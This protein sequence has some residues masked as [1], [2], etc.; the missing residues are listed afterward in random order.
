MTSTIER[1][2]VQMVFEADRFRRGIK[3]SIDDLSA[4]KKSFDFKQAQDSFSELEKASQVDFNPMAKSLEQINGKLSILGVVAAEVIQRITGAIIDNGKRMVDALVLDPILTG[5]SEYETQLNAIQTILANTRKEGVTLEDV[6]DA[7]DELNLYADLTIYNF[8]QMTD[9]IGKFTAAGVPLQD[10]VLAI[11]GIAN[12]AAVSGS[13]SQQA[14]V[15]MYQL[16][17]AISTGSLKLQDWNSVVNAGMGGQ[18]FQDALIQTARTYGVAV[19]DMIADAGSFRASLQEGWITSEILLQTLAQFTGDLSD[20]ELEALGYT[21]DEIAAIQE[22][23]ETAVDAATKIKTL[24]QLGD[25][26]KEALQSGWSES[27]R[28]IF[29][30]FEEAKELWGQ[31]AEFFGKFIDASADARNELLQTWKNAGGRTKL[32]AGFLNVMQALANIL[33]AVKAGFEAIFKPLDAA[34]L[35]RITDAFYQFSKRLLSASEN[36]GPLRIIVM[37][38]AAA[39]DVVFIFIK[40]L[41]APL[42][43]LAPALRLGAGSFADLLVG[44][45]QAI[46]KFRDFAK[47]TGFFTTLVAS[48]IAGVKALVERIKELVQGFIELEVVQTVIQWFKDLDRQDFIN[49]WQGFLNV[50]RAIAVPFVAIGYAARWVYTEFMKLDAVKEIIDWFN[51]ISLP[52]I[53]Q[54]FVDMGEGMKSFVESIKESDVT[55]KF[56]NYLSTFDGRRIKQ[57][58]ADAREG[59]GW[60][61]TGSDSAKS[62]LA[63]LEPVFENVKAELNKIKDAIGEA[64]GSLFD[65][66]AGKAETIDYS[67]LFDVINTGLFAGLILS[68]RKLADMFSLDT[69][70]GDTEFG[71]AIVEDLEEL[72]NVLNGMALNLKADALKN[73][74]IGIALLAGSVYLLTFIDSERLAIATGAIVAMTAGLAIAVRQLGG[75]NFKSAAASSVS[76]IAISLALL[77][78]AEAMED[79]SKIDPERLGDSLKAIGLGMAGLVIAIS[80]IAKSDKELFQTVFIMIGLSKAINSLAKAMETFGRMEPEVLEQGMWAVSAALGVLTAAVVIM[81]RIGKGGGG[82]KA[83]GGMILLATSL[84]IMAKAVE[85]FGLMKPNVAAEGLKNIGIAMGGFAVFSQLIKPQGLIKAAIALTIMS[86]ALFILLEAIKAYGKLEW[87]ELMMGLAGMGLAL[88]EVI[89]ATRLMT[90]AMSGAIAIAVVAGALVVLATAIKILASLSWEELGIALAAIAGVLIILGVAG[91]LLAPV[92]PVLVSL[93]GAFFLLGIGALAL[94][95]GILL[96][97]IGLTALAGSA[98]AIAAAIPIVGDAIIEILPRLAEAFAEA[99]IAFVVTLAEQAPRLMEAFKTL[100]LEMIGAITDPEFIP[101]I[102]GMI[103]DFVATLLQEFTTRLPYFIDQGYQILLAL[104][105]GFK[106]NVA[107]LVTAGFDIVTEVLKGIEDGA[108]DVIDQ[109]FSTILTLIEAFEDAIDEYLHQIVAA[110]LRVGVAIIEGLIDGIEEGIIDVK[111]ALLDLAQKAWQAVVDFFKFDSPSKLAYDAAGLIVQ[112]LVNGITDSIG[113]AQA[114]F[115]EMGNAFQDEINSLLTAMVSELEEFPEFNPVVSPILNLDDLVREA[116]TISKYGISAG[117]AGRLGF[118]DTGIER[119]GYA[120]EQTETRGQQASIIF[121][122]NNYSPKALDREVI[123]RQTRTQVA[124]LQQERAFG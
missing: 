122:Q 49:L 106:D 123:Y 91:Y 78:V 75:L 90:G 107:D 84:L 67:R 109:G 41:L 97:A 116:E 120:P 48:I 37:G 52:D 72:G 113:Q 40:A 103:F 61:K 18:V 24:T 58:L 47:E 6:T 21:K 43:L 46:I 74:A 3:Q 70:F 57:F 32:I 4:L 101:K 98:Y 115:Q 8:T 20:A 64:L 15:A 60:M 39:L 35:Y 69:I 121:N 1:R 54:A 89:V 88:L 110:G 66:L 102:A 68:I 51:N 36:A 62:A 14:S 25:T 93:A 77:I 82:A 13:N 92:V 44:V 45:A 114:A 81:D 76:M 117:I 16:S 105:Q 119:A 100:I 112:G 85:Q 56:L 28:Y 124:K 19:D 34:G 12:L 99:I 118:I 42:K 30:D 53:R 59:F 83:G 38:L 96:A 71:E 31:V 79:V 63:G 55:Q 104:I 80:S 22:Q 94:G 9:N 11:K 33:G 50:L 29:G 87:E 26:M 10:S 65:Y 27:W 2:I 17:Q 23:A 7:L 73:I 108:P 95:L 111:E 5:L 86:G